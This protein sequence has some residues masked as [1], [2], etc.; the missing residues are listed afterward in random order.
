MEVRSRQIAKQKE[1]IKNDNIFAIHL[2]K[3]I[4]HTIL[5]L[6]IYKRKES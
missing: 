5:M 1:D 6:D 4:L 3:A 2:H